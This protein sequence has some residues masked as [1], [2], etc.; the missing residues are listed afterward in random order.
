[1]GLRERKKAATRRTL[2]RAAVRLAMERGSES[3]TVDD[4]VAAADVSKRTFFN[5]FSSKDEAIVGDGPPRPDDEAREIFVAQGPTG[6][7][8][9]DLK[10][11]LLAPLAGTDSDDLRQRLA[12]I[13]ERKRL[14]Q[15][16]PQLTPRLMAA[17]A[18]MERYV[19]ESVAERL[20]ED[21]D[22]IRPQ[23]VASLGITAM[24][25]SM[26]RLQTHSAA[27]GS[28]D[29]QDDAAEFRA[30]FDQAFDALRR[31]FRPAS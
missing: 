8:L 26:R 2:Q 31:T 22:D 6:D 11:F 18:D 24:R 7:L 20:G 3:V 28:A 12:D 14:V 10:V 17:F 5:Y 25:F 30:L 27:S 15:Q 29:S 16:E 13:R 1:M 9:E 21:P 4:I 19:G 23:I